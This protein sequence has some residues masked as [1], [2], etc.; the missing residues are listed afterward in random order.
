VPMVPPFVR[1]LAANKV[2]DRIKQD[3]AIIDIQYPSLADKVAKK[4]EKKRIKGRVEAGDP[5]GRVA[6]GQ[7]KQV[8][9]KIK[10]QF[11]GHSPM[12]CENWG[13]D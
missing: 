5:I 13:W 9:S 7:W 8:Q 12:S 3:L 1:D 2:L 11:S 4:K 10:I 6:P